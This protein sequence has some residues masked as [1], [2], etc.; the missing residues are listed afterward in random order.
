MEVLPVINRKRALFF[1]LIMASMLLLMGCRD[2]DLIREE[3]KE[4]A[5]VKGEGRIEIEDKSAGGTGKAS[6]VLQQQSTY[7]GWYFTCF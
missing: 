4:K 7:Q 1:F 2:D 3:I 6:S 5:I